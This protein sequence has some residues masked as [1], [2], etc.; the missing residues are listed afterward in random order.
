MSERR[1]EGTANGNSNGHAGNGTSR[2]AG[3]LV[4]ARQAAALRQQWA[5]DP[6]P[7]L[8]QGDA[9]GAPQ[10]AQPLAERCQV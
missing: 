9:P 3:Q 2:P 4:L 6:L 8:G 7:Q 10:M 1:L 5:A